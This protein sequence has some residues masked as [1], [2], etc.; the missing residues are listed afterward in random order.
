LPGSLKRFARKPSWLGVDEYARIALAFSDLAITKLRFTGGEPLLRQDLAAIVGVFR[1][2]MPHTALSLTTNGQYLPASFDDL[3]KAGISRINVHIDSLDP[4]K[5]KRI[6][7]NGDLSCILA[8]L[9]AMKAALDE[10]KINVVLQK[11][12]NDDEL[13]H[14]IAYSQRTGIEVRF[15]EQMNTGSAPEHVKSTFLPGRDAID[16]IKK[17]YAVRHLG[18]RHFSDPADLYAI[19]QTAFGLIASDTQP[20]CSACNRLRLDAQGGLRGCLYQGD[21]IG[22]GAMMRAGASDL[23]LR[24]A[25]MGAVANKRSYHPI[26]GLASQR[27][28]SMAEIGG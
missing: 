25:V 21:G 27:P 6:M 5:Y 19:D 3:R 2:H 9:P 11:G 23:E 17:H 8:A 26:V 4:V 1:E 13:P 10:L 24:E 22:L 28:F 18:R 15:I 16:I 12:V 14:F 7:G 20:F